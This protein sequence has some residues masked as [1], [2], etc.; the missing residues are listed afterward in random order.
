MDDLG[1]LAEADLPGELFGYRIVEQLP[2]S[3]GR[4]GGPGPRL[5]LA[6]PR[7]RPGLRL[8]LKDY[9]D[10]TESDARSWAVARRRAR[11]AWEVGRRLSHPSLMRVHRPVGATCLAIEWIDGVTLGD[12]LARGHVPHADAVTIV[13]DLAGALVHLTTELSRHFPAW[14]GVCHPDVSGVNVMVAQRSGRPRAVLIDLDDIGKSIKPSL[15]LSPKRMEAILDAGR[16]VWQPPECTLGT[17]AYCDSCA[18]V[19]TLGILGFGLLVGR[20]PFAA[21]DEYLGLLHRLLAGEN[22]DLLPSRIAG[23]HPN[24]AQRV[25][26]RMTQF[27][28]SRRYPSVEAALFDLQRVLRDNGAA[29][30][31]AGVAPA[32]GP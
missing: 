13:L 18:N 23:A 22:A 5:Y 24:A 31:P 9:A 10:G 14:P 8:L 20:P 19:F 27:D 1:A 30:D 28:R 26:A 3:P 25:L 17:I 7:S 21:R 15:P 16:R 4:L 32:T 29:H 11:A 2:K 6:E 12:L